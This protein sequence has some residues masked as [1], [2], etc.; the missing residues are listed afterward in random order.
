MQKKVLLFLGFLLFSFNLFCQNVSPLPYGVNAHLVKNNVLAKIKSAGIKWIRIDIFWNLVEYQKGKYNYTEVDRVI[1]YAH[2]NGLSVLAVLTGTPNWACSNK[3]P[4]YPANN[5]SNWSN[6]VTKMVQRYKSKVK[7]WNIWNEP[8]LKR[9]FIYDKDV[10]VNKIFLPGAKALR[11][12]D[13]SAFIVG[14]GLSHSQEQDQE[15]FFWLKYILTT[16]KDYIDVVSHHMYKD[17]GPYYMYISLEEG[18]HFL[19]AVKEI[20]EE[21]GH[22]DKPFWIA[23]TG[24]H[25]GKFSESVQADYYLEMLQRRK[26]KDYPNKIF[27]YEIIDDPSPGANPFGILMANLREKTAFEV[28]RDFIAGKYPDF[29]GDDPEQNSEKCYFEETV[30]NT[31]VS[32]N[33][34]FMNQLRG[35]RDGMIGFSTATENLVR[36]YYALGDEM[37]KVSMSDSRIFS[38]STDLIGKLDELLTKGDGHSLFRQKLDRKTILKATQLIILLKEKELSP[39]LSNLVRWGEAQL[40]HIKN[41]SIRD[42]F[43]RHTEEKSSKIEK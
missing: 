33:S 20:I 16:C 38:L 42:I 9:F 5:V 28:Y 40:E 31:N 23:E 6:F 22:G 11:S 36:S 34:G 12:A 24:W 10:F 25:T 4:N 26:M 14:P 21:T 43:I 39:A 30:A 8:N 17:E 3:G 32:V 2:K 15:W 7:Y 37:V 19:P 35:F 27:F 29:E 41:R 18:E 13:R 1:N